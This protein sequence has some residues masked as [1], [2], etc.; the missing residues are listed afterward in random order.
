MARAYTDKLPDELKI[1][2]ALKCIREEISQ[3]DI[4][5][6]LIEEWVRN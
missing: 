6:K 4:L 5:V 2:F 1:E 3:G